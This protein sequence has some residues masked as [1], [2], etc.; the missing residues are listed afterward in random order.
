MSRG[1]RPRA[2]VTRV[3]NSLFVP[4]PPRPFHKLNE[5]DLLQLRHLFKIIRSEKNNTPVS[6]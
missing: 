4:R 1:K 3:K 6:S 5:F 2:D